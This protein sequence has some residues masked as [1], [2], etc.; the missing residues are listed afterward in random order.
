M[1]YTLYF[2]Y[3]KDFYYHVLQKCSL[4]TLIRGFMWNIMQK[5]KWYPITGFLK[6]LMCAFNEGTN[7]I[8]ITESFSPLDKC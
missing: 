6:I 7:H 2:Y 8:C 3:L 5:E 4:K 1:V